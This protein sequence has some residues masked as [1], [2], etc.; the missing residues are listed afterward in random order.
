MKPLLQIASP[1]T[2]VIIAS[3]VM[4]SDR[5][6]PPLADDVVSHVLRI[7]NVIRIVDVDVVVV[8]VDGCVAHVASSG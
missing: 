4:A 8:R 5:T 7:G 2:A 3:P 6:E 1:Q